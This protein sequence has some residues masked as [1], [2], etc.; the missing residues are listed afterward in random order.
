LPADAAAAG[1]AP[2]SPP[3]GREFIGLLLI[4]AIVGTIVSLAAWLFLEATHQLQ[5]GVYDKLPGQL[6]Y[7][8]GAPT[9][10]P[11]PVCGIAGLLVAAAIMRLPG[12]GGHIPAMG[13]SAGAAR[14]AELPGIILAALATVGLGLVL[15]PEAPLIA[16]G[17]GLGLLAMRLANK[18]APPTVLTVVAAAGSF[19]AMSFLFEAPMI[20]AVLM[21]EASGIGGKQLPLL[22]IPGL[23]ASAIGSLV[24]IG[25]GSFSGL[26]TSAYAIGAL[27]LP[28]FPRPTVVDFAWTL[29]VAAAITLVCLAAML[30]G[31]HVQPFVMRAP[32]LLI[33]V[34]GLV[35]AALAIVFSQVTDKGVEQVLFSGQDAIG[36]LAANPGAWSVG[37]LFAVLL[38]K[39][40]AWGVSLGGFRGGPTFPAMFVG[41][42]AG[43]LA[44]HL[45]GFDVTPAVAV[46]IGAGVVAVLRL[47][48]SAVVLATV[49]TTNSG[50]GDTP[51]IIVGVVVAYAV[52]MGLAPRLEALSP[53]PVEPRRQAADAGA[54]DVPDAAP[55]GV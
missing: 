44:S 11:L 12:F 7:D 8:S 18:D 15:G 14:P 29:P 46:G 43:V 45:P 36:P 4:A 16:L 28:D 40:L 31:R 19:A 39:G 54:T 6:G 34:A 35:V 20:A 2:E 26:S 32:F 23:L 9:W 33:P 55:A 53:D 37:A 47:P 52:T 27:N 42:A 51:L 17:S 38:F 22:L 30:I 1:A 5:V 50:V 3:R 21:I 41:A 13:L 49:L 48:L 24:S 25:L 10:W